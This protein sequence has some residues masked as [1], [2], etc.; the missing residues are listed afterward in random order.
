LPP[1]LLDLA[2]EGSRVLHL[3]DFFDDARLICPAPTVCLQALLQLF[4]SFLKF[5]FFIVNRMNILSL[6]LKLT[7][8]F[9]QSLVDSF[10]L[11]ELVLLLIGVSF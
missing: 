2:K 8:N 5:R 7:I 1:Q 10:D 9:L 11:A 4:Y 6:F 3:C